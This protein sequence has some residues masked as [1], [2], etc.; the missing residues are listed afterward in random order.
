MELVELGE[1]LVQLHLLE[2]LEL[3][4]AGRAYVDGC[5]HFHLALPLLG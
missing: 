1:F 5:L 2:A 4:V 3:A